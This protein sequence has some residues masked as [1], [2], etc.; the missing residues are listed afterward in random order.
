M[1]PCGD[2]AVDASFNKVRISFID[3]LEGTVKLI[4]VIA[5]DALQIWGHR[6]KLTDLLENKTG[7]D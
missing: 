7:H 4:R 2:E 5:A 6:T 1:P 3:N